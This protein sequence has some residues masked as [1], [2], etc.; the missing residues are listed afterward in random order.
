V[1]RRRRSARRRRRVGA[2]RRA[3]RS[4][5]ASSSLVLRVVPVLAEGAEQ[6][7]VFV[8]DVVER[9]LERAARRGLGLREL[10]AMAGAVGEEVDR[11]G[12]ADADAV[13]EDR[14]WL[15]RLQR[16]V[17]QLNLL[18]WSRARRSPC[19]RSMLTSGPRTLIRQRAI[20]RRV[21]WFMSELY[22]VTAAT[23]GGVDIDATCP[24][25]YVL[26][27]TS[28]AAPGNTRFVSTAAAA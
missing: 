28:P 15:L 7:G 13:D 23:W 14:R 3:C 11:L 10:A 26:R 8:G 1:G 21:S 12:D 17:A 24:K 6:G 16:R 9:A 20:A 19:S 27:V 22:R 5:P 4:G 2:G 18:P 25:G